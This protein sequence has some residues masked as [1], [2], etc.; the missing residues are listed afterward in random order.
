MVTLQTLLAPEDSSSSTQDMAVFLSNKISTATA[1][2]TSFPTLHPLAL[3][4]ISNGILYQCSHMDLS[5]APPPPPLDGGQLV[6]AL[7][8]VWG[9]LDALLNHCPLGW[10]MRL[11]KVGTYGQS[12][13]LNSGF[14]TIAGSFLKQLIW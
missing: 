14:R 13:T 2:L 6:G 1:A 5:T 4:I 3:E 12:Q 11:F 7:R 9:L 8:G 10:S